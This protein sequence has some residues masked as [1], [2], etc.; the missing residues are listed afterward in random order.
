M[1]IPSQSSDDQNP[2][3][4]LGN[5]SLQKDPADP[6]LQD[7]EGNLT[8]ETPRVGQPRSFDDLPDSLSS[9]ERDQAVAALAFLSEVRA[10]SQRSDQLPAMIGRYSVV[11][12][13]G[14]GGFAEV[15][16]AEDQELGRRVALKVPLFNSSTNEAGRQRFEREAKLAAS[17]GHPQ[18]VPVYEYGNLGAVRFIAF[19][20]CDGSNLADWI[21]EHGPVDFET[22]AQ[23]VLHLA[24]AVQHAHQRGIVHRDLKPSNVLVDNSAEFSDKPLWERL[25][26]TDFG[27]AR[28]FDSHDATLTQDGQL[29]GTPAYMAPEQAGS[30]EDVGPA[31]D[32]W[33]LGMVLFELLTGSLPFRR[34]EILATIRAICD[35]PMPKARKLRS[36]VPV[37]LDAIA[38]LCLRKNPAAR[39]PSAHALAEDLNRW[40]NGEP[41]Q[42]KPLSTLSMFAMWTRRNPVVTSLIGLTIASLAIGLGVALW[43]RNVAIDNLREAQAQTNRADGNLETAQKLFKAIIGLEVKLRGQSH[44]SK[45]RASL[46]KQAA[47]LQ[48]ELVEDEEQ[49]PQIRYATAMSLKELSG[50]L[51]ELQNFEAGLA[52]AERVIGLLEGLEEPLPPGVSPLQLFVTRLE[53]RIKMAG[54]LIA[55][56]REDEALALYDANELEQAPENIHP[57]VLATYRSETLRA[58]SVLFQKN[59]DSKNSAIAIRQA[60]EYLETVEPS[61]DKRQ[62]WNYSLT[63]ARLK[64][65][66]GIDETA[67]DELDAAKASFVQSG[68]QLSVMK[69]LFPNHPIIL[70]TEGL[71]TF[72]L[73]SLYE[74]T[75]EWAKA[76]EQYRQC[77]EIQL[78]MFEQNT[79][80]TIPANMFVLASLALSRSHRQ[81]GEVDSSVAIAETTIE[82]AEAFPN[83]LKADQAF[84]DNMA[85]LKKFL[86]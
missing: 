62:I 63:L 74:R 85:Q 12:S 11:K 5:A 26:I 32:V 16:L 79:A 25:R 8:D 52:N 29:V 27:L 38:D 78:A 81:N 70:Q 33:A 44:L 7:T 58:R 64:M 3:K 41:I 82:T 47:Q 30:G 2:K 10:E 71:L 54:S 57:L 21:V 60:L 61:D 69:E 13:I 23:M 50:L 34:P 86:P 18:I 24:A 39:Y 4:S 55:M 42:A 68:E 35:D 53:Q 28:N 48:V 17:L 83:S 46:I 77:R 31:A 56:G 9:E 40:I 84:K 15:F 43:Q 20:W 49:S 19:A 51:F 14:R 6:V 72:H 59:G 45:E 1:T 73:G 66:L 36:E 80:L 65:S 22:A 37:G 67:L 76:A 75:E